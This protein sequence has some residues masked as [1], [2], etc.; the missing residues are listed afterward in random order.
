MNRRM[1]DNMSLAMSDVYA[2]CVDRILV[3][4]A[5]HF[6]FIKEGAPVP[7][8]WDYQIRKLAEMGQVTQESERIILETLGGADE[9][10]QAM[11]EA[12]IMDSLKGLDKPLKQA[13]ERGLTLGGGIIPPEIAPRQ[14]QA[15]AAYYQQS[16]DKL[17]LVN[18]VMLESTQQAYAATVADI[19]TKIDTTQKILN[20]ATGQVVTGTESFNKVLH[21]SVRQ[22]VDNG[23]TG[24]IDH[25]GHHWSPEAYVAMD[26]RTT[27][28]NTGRAAVWEQAD[29]YGVDLYQV[30]SHDGARPLCYPWQGKV[31]S[32]NGWTGEVEDGD[33]NKVTVH[34]ESEIESFRYGGGLFGVNCGHYP[35]PFVPGFSR[36]RPPEQNEEQNAKEYAESQQ[37]RALERELRA[38]RRE[39]AVMKAQGA[40]DEE[41]QA[42]KFR[43][44]NASKNLDD[45]CDETGRARQRAREYTPI[46]ATFPDGYKQTKYEQGIKRRDPNKP[47]PA[48]PAP[49][50]PAPITPQKP[51]AERISDYDD[52]I[53]KMDEDRIAWKKTFTDEERRQDWFKKEDE[54]RVAEI[55]KLKQ[56]RNSLKY[57]ENLPK[58]G[59]S[60]RSLTKWDHTPTTDEIIA[61]LGGLDKTSGSC[62]SLTFAYAGNRGGY[63]VLD[64]RGGNSRYHFSMCSNIDKIANIPGIDGVVL[65]NRSDYTTAHQLMA[66]MTEGKEY[67]FGVAK[68]AAVVRKTATG[69]EYLEMQGGAD[70]NGF[71]ELNDNVLKWRFGCRKSHTI[72]GMPH[73]IPGEL[74][75]IDKMKENA[76]FLEVLKYINTAASEQKKGVGGGLR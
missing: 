7:A 43:V 55:D 6:A 37:Q 34:S 48:Q 23:I 22:M 17:N 42:Q 30:S 15:F 46:N 27:M 36:I 69:F 33:G 21:D 51:I 61:N 39:L 3:N 54:K 40:T 67:F 75:E 19:A 18:T 35:I 29:Q 9:A 2:A 12:T 47:T 50:Q 28:T 31:I 72:Y 63:D 8:S 20:A 5:R 13:A 56:E 44:K 62:A 49:A 73:E 10:L 71:K 76:D 68:H 66:Q 1:I 14:M 4:L 45:F 57:V 24:F 64:F 74:M 25:G 16:A 38:E 65:R 52:R 70:Y 41:I 53:I 58:T 60:E 11:L 32:R 59:I 26:T